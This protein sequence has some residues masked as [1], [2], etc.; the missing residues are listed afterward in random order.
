[1]QED[2]LRVNAFLV[3]LFIGSA[4]GIALGAYVLARYNAV[5][6]L[7]GGALF[8]IALALIAGVAA[9]SGFL[10]TAALLQHSGAAA[11]RA[12]AKGAVAAFTG[13]FLGYLVGAMF[14]AA[15]GT[16]FAALIVP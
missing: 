16:L 1:M 9:G 2:K 10:G 13:F 7:D 6:A 4:I 5:I 15:I 8:G 3:S 11:F 14:G 12:A